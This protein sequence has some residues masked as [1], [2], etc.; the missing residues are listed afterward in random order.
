VRTGG[1]HYR[2]VVFPPGTDGRERWLLR[3]GQWWPFAGLWPAL[4]VLGVLS[5]P[6]GLPSATMAAT[7]M[8]LGPL[9]WLRRT[10]RRARRDL[11]VVHAD[12]GFGPRTADD[13]ERCKRLLSLAW[14]ATR[15]E[16]ALD[17]GELTPLEFQRVWGEVHAEARLLARRARSVGDGQRAA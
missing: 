10:V 8:F 17:R 14:D 9:V 7:A 16:R 4:V 3:A 12:L 6:V 1:R 15:A 11:C 2:L 13:A 5:T